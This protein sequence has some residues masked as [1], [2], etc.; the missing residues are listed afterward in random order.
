MRAA[1]VSDG[2]VAT[3]NIDMDPLADGEFG[4]HVRPITEHRDPAKRRDAL[5]KLRGFDRARG[6]FDGFNE[7]SV[8]E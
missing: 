7:D 2:D 1:F 3:V 6:F 4:W 5:G 8:A